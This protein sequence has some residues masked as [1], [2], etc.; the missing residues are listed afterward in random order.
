M[1]YALAVLSLVLAPLGATASATD[2]QV[3]DKLMKKVA[4]PASD[5]V[6]KFKPRFACACM[7]DAP[8]SPG[9]ILRDNNGKI[10]CGK[11]IFNGDGEFAA[12]FGCSD[13]EVIGR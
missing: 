4:P 5:L 11:L 10:F 2:Q 9:V 1:R 7:S 13:F 8:P 12:Y 6:D 3:F